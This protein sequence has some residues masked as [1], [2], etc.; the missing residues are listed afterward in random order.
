MRRNWR[1][2]LLGPLALAMALDCG[3]KRSDAGTPAADVVANEHG[4]SPASLKLTQGGAGS[5]ATVTFV[6]TT[7]RTCA[8]AVV[9]PDLNLQRDLPLDKVVS[10]EV[11]TDSARTLSFQCGMGM[12]KGA[13]VVTSK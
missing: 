12:Y 3:C 1:L 11:P 10:V 9:F 5:H 4:F 8:T 6:R 2:A 13:L 7:D